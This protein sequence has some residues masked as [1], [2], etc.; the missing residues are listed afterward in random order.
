M[1]NNN[2]RNKVIFAIEFIIMAIS[3]LAFGGLMLSFGSMIEAW[4]I[5][6]TPLIIGII[7]GAW[8]GLISLYTYIINR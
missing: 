5:S 4:S 3:L 6:K 8:L 1:S 2:K 7:C